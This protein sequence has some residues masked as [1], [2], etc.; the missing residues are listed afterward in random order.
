MAKNRP[1]ELM[2]TTPP[3]PVTCLLVDDHPALL[4]ALT[5]A[6]TDA[7]VRVVG[8]AMSAAAGLALLPR[9]PDVV[10]L[11]MRLP[12]M[13]GIELA[14][15]I[16]ASGTPAKTLLYSGH[17]DP[18]VAGQVLAAGM[19]GLIAKGSPLSEVVRAV[20]AVAAGGSYVDPLLGAA[21]A[22]GAADPLSLSER[23]EALL[24]HISRGLTDERIGE[25]LHL[26][27]ETIRANVRRVVQTMGA[28]NRTHAV[29]LALRTGQLR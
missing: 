15:A 22:R 26:S 24:G 21:L 18:R 28:K 9:R 8:A 23:D 20:R 7:G 5:R 4:D 11:D 12:D 29:A 14:Q 27:P 3:P 6:L 17:V 2:N 1:S 25:E 13:T 10:L 19:N 16:A